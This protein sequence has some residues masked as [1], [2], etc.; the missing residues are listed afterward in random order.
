MR[1]KCDKKGENRRVLFAVFDGRGRING[2]LEEWLD[3]Q[4]QVVMAH[5][6]GQG[7]AYPRLDMWRNQV[8]DYFLTQ[9]KAAYLCLVDDDMVPVEATAEFLACDADVVVCSYR[10]RLGQPCHGGDGEGGCGMMK[11]SRQAAKKMG[12]PWFA[13][14]A[15]SAG[16]DVVMCECGFFSGKA[17]NAGFHP[18]TRGSVGHVAEAVLLPGEDPNDQAYQIRLLPDLTA[19]AEC[20]RKYQQHMKDE[21][22]A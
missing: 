17:K 4:A 16:T 6:I 2:V 10:N 9:T 15:N 12:A 1:A 13:F 22:N 5:R 7:R 8:V 21:H 20:E 3:R 14:V 11:I 18:V 19:E